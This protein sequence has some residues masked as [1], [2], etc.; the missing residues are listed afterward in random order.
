MA[1]YSEKFRAQMVKRML[2]PSGMTANQLSSKVGVSQST[3]SKWLRDSVRDVGSGD[4]DDTPKTTTNRPRTALERMELVVE[5]SKL[6]EAELGA[7]LRRKGIHES[8]LQEWRER[9]EGALTSTSKAT[10]SSAKDK[11]R[12]KALE[13]DL[14]KKEKALAE[15]A[16]LLVLQKK[17]QEIWGDADDDTDERNE[18]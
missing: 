3:L 1:K 9:L 4:N 10:R 14:R 15:T 13:R 6:E 5:A 12:I 8:E 18:G 11:K 7:F 17:V 2:G 16:A